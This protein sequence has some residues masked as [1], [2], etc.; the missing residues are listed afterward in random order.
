M[1]IARWSIALVLPLTLVVAS[2]QNADAQGKGKGHGGGGGGEKKEHGQAKPERGAS[3]VRVD[4]GQRGKPQRVDDQ[5]RGRG[6]DKVE[7]AQKLTGR[8]NAVLRPNMASGGEVGR[9]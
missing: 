6:N 2:A 8:D 7:K 1:R 9:E 3:T 5:G 4:N